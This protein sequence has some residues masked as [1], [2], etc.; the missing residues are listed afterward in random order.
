MR[1]SG[2]DTPLASLN[3]RYMLIQ[4]NQNLDEYLF[5]AAALAIIGQDGNVSEDGQGYGM[6][7]KEAEA[8]YHSIDNYI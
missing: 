4:N 3:M 5:V 6:K 2:V 7:K 8:D 1:S